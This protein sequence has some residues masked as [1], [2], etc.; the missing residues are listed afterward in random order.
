MTKQS[1]EPGC[2]C[3]CLIL[4]FIFL[5]WLSGC[6]I[7]IGSFHAYINPA[8]GCGMTNTDEEAVAP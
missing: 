7:Q 3:G 4:I 6:N 8:A 2:G 1:D 5:V